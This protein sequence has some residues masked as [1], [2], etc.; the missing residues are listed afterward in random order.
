MA[1][2]F[3]TRSPLA[4]ELVVVPDPVARAGRWLA[5][6]VRRLA[7]GPCPAEIRLAIPGGSALAAVARAAAELGE[8][9]RRVAL[10]WV[11]ERCVPVA[12]PDSN[13][14]EAIRQ[15]LLPPES[16]CASAPAIRISPARVLPLFEDG[17]SPEAALA[18]VARRYA[19]ELAGRLD[20]VVLGMGADGHVAS[21][22][23][24][25]PVST[26]GCVA[27]VPDAPKAPSRRITLTRSALA[28][29]R[30]TLLV[31]VGEEKREALARLCAGD[32]RLAATGLP[33]LVVVTDLELHGAP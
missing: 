15:G 17:E 12:S 11:D 16:G 31:A 29:A 14:G 33:G 1:E 25:L 18:R 3:A 9:W 26:N 20:V 19:G 21:L 2:R 23:P 8:V 32:P 27:F 4:F 22:F 5:D 13:R 6:C 28:T 24:E 7:E 10:T 30:H